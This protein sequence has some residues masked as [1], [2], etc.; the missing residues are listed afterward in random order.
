MCPDLSAIEAEGMMARVAAA[1]RER[2]VPATGLNGERPPFVTLSIGI[3]ECSKPLEIHTTFEAAD[4]EAI[5]SKNG[6]KN[7]IS[8][9]QRPAVA[10][11]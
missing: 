3:A 4:Q 5:R 9:G 2:P 10:A 11:S 6:G 8:I 7:R 1:L